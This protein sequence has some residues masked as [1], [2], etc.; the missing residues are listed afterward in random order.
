MTLQRSLLRTDE[1]S[2][3]ETIGYTSISVL[4]N[5]WKN[6]EIIITKP[7]KG[8]GVAILDQK[9]YDSAI[10]K[11]I[12][13][14][15]KFEKLDESP[16]LKREA[17]LQHFLRKLKQKN[18]FNENEYNKLYPSGSA[19]ARIYGTPEMHKFSSSD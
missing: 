4:Q 10:K 19:P 14:T 15:S 6:K 16:T 12:I 5:R 8:N 1:A 17:S 9:L 2:F 3:F 18:V 7:D 13:D 11:I